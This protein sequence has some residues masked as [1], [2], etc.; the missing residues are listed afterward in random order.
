MTHLDEG[1]TWMINDTV[2]GIMMFVIGVVPL[3]LLHMIPMV[4]Y[5]THIFPPLLEVIPQDYC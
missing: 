4:Q 2:S 5:S 3:D 1:Y